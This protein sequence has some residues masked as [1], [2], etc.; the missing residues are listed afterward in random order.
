MNKNGIS[1]FVF[2][3]FLET[4]IILHRKYSFTIPLTGQRKPRFWTVEGKIDT[5]NKC[6]HLSVTE[7]NASCQVNVQKDGFETISHDFL[8]K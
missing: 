1:T 5:L 2:K 6:Y 7:Y 8:D 4:Y 3:K